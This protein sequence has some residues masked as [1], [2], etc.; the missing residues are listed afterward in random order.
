MKATK[1]FLSGLSLLALLGSA[2]AATF[3]TPDGVLNNFG[4]FDWTSSASVLVKGYDIRA[5]QP[6]NSIGKQDIID[7]YYNSFANAV[8]DANGGTFT[9]AGLVKGTG[10]AGYEITVKAHFQEVVTCLD[11]NCTFVSITPLTGTWDIYLDTSADANLLTQSG[12][13]DGVNILS[14]TFTG[15]QTVATSQASVNPG[16][17]TTLASVQGNTT[18]TN[19]AYINP[20]LNGTTVSST[21]SF[22]PKNATNGPNGTWVQPTSWQG[23]GIGGGG[24]GVPAIGGNQRDFVG[25][26]D[27]SQSFFF[28]VPEPTSLAL[29]GFALL[30]L[31]LSARRRKQA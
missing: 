20:N 8:L 22:G 12:F 28:S 24:N 30:G 19:N 4:G 13:G 1:K 21:L 14:G 2:N 17:G 29:T 6:G 10:G 3:G 23:S 25:Q 16:T 7:V 5:N 9:T 27:A 15:G 11:A 18:S 31:G 26:A